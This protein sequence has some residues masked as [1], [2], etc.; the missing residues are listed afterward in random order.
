VPEQNCPFFPTS[1]AKFWRSHVSPRRYFVRPL[2][3]GV[4]FAPI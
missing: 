3:D 2:A 4:R 1:P